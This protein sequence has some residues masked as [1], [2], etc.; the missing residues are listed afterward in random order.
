MVLVLLVVAVI[1]VKVFRPHWLDSARGVFAN[2]TEQDDATPQGHGDKQP[3]KNLELD[4]ESLPPKASTRTTSLVRN[5][6][7]M[8]KPFYDAENVELSFMPPKAQPVVNSPSGKKSVRAD[9]ALA[10]VIEN[11]A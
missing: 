3:D 4:Q 9:T 1:L 10:L 2:C 6:A 7:A 11:E 8:A 5:P